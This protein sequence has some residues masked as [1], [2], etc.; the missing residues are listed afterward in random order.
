MFGKQ[1]NLLV[2]DI[3]LQC[4]TAEKAMAHHFKRSKK[5]YTRRITPFRGWGCPIL[6]TNCP[7]SYTCPMLIAETLA[8]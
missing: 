2:R 3:E 4:S 6:H 8:A 7:F 1:I 5:L